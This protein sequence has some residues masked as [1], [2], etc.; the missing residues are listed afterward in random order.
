MT[1][2]ITHLIL[3]QFSWKSQ[4]Y[5]GISPTFY[6]YFYLY[7]IESFILI[8]R[9]NVKLTNCVLFLDRQSYFIN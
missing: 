3:G 2:K 5:F 9:V 8:T 4:E 1:K 6:W 7:W